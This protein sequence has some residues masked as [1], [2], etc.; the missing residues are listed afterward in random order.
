[1]FSYTSY[2]TL[3]NLQLRLLDLKP[4][5]IIIYH[6]VN[7]VHARL[8]WPHE[9]YKGDNSGYR[10]SIYEQNLEHATSFWTYF[11]LGRIVKAKFS[12]HQSNDKK[13]ERFG[14]A[15]TARFYE[16][17]YQRGMKTYPDGIFKEASVAEILHENSPQYFK[18]NLEYMVSAARANEVSVLL[19]TFAFCPD[20]AKPSTYGFRPLKEAI[21]EHNQIIESISVEKAVPLI[22][23]ATLF[24]KD[25]SLYVDDIHVNQKGSEIK[26]SIFGKYLKS[27]QELF[28]LGI[29]K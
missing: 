10:Q 19:S 3:I 1:M 29:E 6:G 18:R 20:T 12:T 5:L 21:E 25:T 15:P 16:L 13:R 23:L 7:D 22:D 26:A 11:N 27:N 14:L 28:N 17:R 2:E 9:A 4:N 8:V 24:P